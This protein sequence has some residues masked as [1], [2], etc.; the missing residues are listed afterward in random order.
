MTGLSALL[1][2]IGLGFRHAADADHVVVVSALL[3]REHSVARAARVAALWGA[4]HTVSFLGIGLLVV[5]A[6]LHAS[7]ALEVAAELLVIAMLLGFGALHALR[8]LWPRERSEPSSRAEQLSSA[9]PLLVGM[10]HGMAGSAGVV[11]LATSAMESPLWAAAYLA[12]F[13]LGSVVGMILLTIVLSYSLQ[14]TRRLGSFARACIAA[15][16]AVLSLGLGLML[17]LGILGNWGAT[18][19]AR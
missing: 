18:D 12:L 13:G 8:S 11:L 2:G 1:L 19:A 4:G 16:P 14:C 9:R 7:P 17:L 5:T 6:G 10:V 15:A 3:D